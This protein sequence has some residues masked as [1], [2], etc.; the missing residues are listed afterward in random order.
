[1]KRAGVDSLLLSGGGGDEASGLLRQDELRF[2]ELAPDECGWVKPIL[3]Q[4]GWPTRSLREALQAVGYRGR[5]ELFS[6]VCCFAGMLKEAYCATVSPDALRISGVGEPVE[7]EALRTAMR[8]EAAGRRGVCPNIVH[9][10]Q[11]TALSCIK[12]VLQ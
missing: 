5:P 3:E 2:L 10:I 8:A 9:F 6:M 7:V 1:M 11:V 12:P 4:A